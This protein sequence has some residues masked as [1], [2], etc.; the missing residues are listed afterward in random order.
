MLAEHR[1]RPRD[2]GSVVVEQHR[3]A[4]DLH[5]AEP[6][7]LDLLDHAARD[8]LR[9]LEHLLEIVDQR[10]GHAG[11][12]Q[13]G[14]QLAGLHLADRRLDEGQQRILVG[15]AVGVGG[16]ARIGEMRAEP[17]HLHEFLEQHV[18]RHADRDVALVARLEQL[19]RRGQAVP[20][21][22]RLRHL[23]GFEI[24]RRLPGRRRDR[25]L[26]QRNVGDAAFAV[27]RRADE[28]RQAS[29]R[30]Q[31][32]R[33][34]RRRSARPAASASRPARRSPTARRRTPR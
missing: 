16:K 18:V 11:L 34:T 10:A 24:F 13:A 4:R 21:A 12:H 9:M 6:R 32:A 1:R 29:R 5:G 26:D 22:H 30:W 28:A 33:R 3:I 7:M 2:V 19:I 23:A 8:D 17:D 27:S 15:L 31:T 14:F 20:V 25:G